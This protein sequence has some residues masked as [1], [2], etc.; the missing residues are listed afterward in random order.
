M[1]VTQQ[2]IRETSG[3][4]GLKT[5]DIRA[6][7]LGINLLDGADPELERTCERV[8]A[9]VVQHARRRCEVAESITDDYGIPIVN[10]RIAVT[11]VAWIA[12]PSGAE[13]LTP[14]AIALD[15]AAAEVGVDFIGGFT[16]HVHQGLT[17]ADRALLDSIPSALAPTHRRCASVPLACTRAGTPLSPRPSLAPSSR[18]PAP[19]RRH[20]PALH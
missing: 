11:P 5:L 4:V 3:I 6:M 7:T 17:H 14:L 18:P 19:G 8:Y 12:G 13:D 2:E 15:A 1:S 20:R 9:K 10:R 16:T